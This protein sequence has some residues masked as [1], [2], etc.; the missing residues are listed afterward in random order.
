MLARVGGLPPGWQL[1]V[2][3][4]RALELPDAS[5]DVLI[6]SYLLQLL[7]PVELPAALAEL[8]RVLRP[9]GRLVTVTPAIPPSRLA[10]PVATARDRLAARPSER[11]RGLRALNPACALERAGFRLLRSR[12]SLR[13]YPS[14]CVL[15]IRPEHGPEQGMTGAAGSSVG[16]DIDP[17]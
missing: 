8:R 7:A 2:G 4:V 12:W 11:Y 10:R 14:V 9:G 1:R 5:V 16:H 15:A 17:G 3:D 6:A 13:G